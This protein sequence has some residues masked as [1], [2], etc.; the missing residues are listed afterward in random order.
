MGLAGAQPQRVNDRYFWEGSK[1]LTF[2][3][4]EFEEHFLSR[5]REEYDMKAKKWISECTAPEYLKLADK[6]FDHEEKYCTTLL[7]PSTR[8]KLMKRVENELI[9]KRNQ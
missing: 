5:A 1:D 7:Q 2:Y 8:P 6:V 4:K 9:S 3:E